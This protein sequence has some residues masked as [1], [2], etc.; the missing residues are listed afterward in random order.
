MMEPGRKWKSPRARAWERLTPKERER[1]IRA[2]T[3]AHAEASQ[4]FAESCRIASEA[5]AAF[6]ES[7]AEMKARHASASSLRRP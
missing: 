4:Q 1:R 3:D 5:L 2:I 7:L 6:A